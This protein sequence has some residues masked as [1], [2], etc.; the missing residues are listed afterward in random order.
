M[1]FVLAPVYRRPESFNR[2]KTVLR[3]PIAVP[4]VISSNERGEGHFMG[5]GH[6]R[7]DAGDK[8]NGS[9]AFVFHRLA[10]VI[11]PS[12]FCAEKAVS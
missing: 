8:K 10:N 6:C 1:L 12:S 3:A 4:S 5:H 11:C 7:A 2:M 9:I